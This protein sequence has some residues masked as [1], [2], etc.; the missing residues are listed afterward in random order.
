MMSWLI[1]WW[2]RPP[3][4]ER[5]LSAMTREWRPGLDIIRQ[6][7]VSIGSFYVHAL[8]MEDAGL[9][10]SKW[11]EGPIDPR[12]GGHRR[13]LYRL[14]A[15]GRGVIEVHVLNPKENPMKPAIIA[16]AL[17]ILTANAASAQSFNCDTARRSDERAICDS[18]ELSR[19]DRQLNRAYRDALRQVSNPIRIQYRQRIWLSERRGCGGNE[20][21]LRRAY[22]DRIGELQRLSY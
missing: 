19:L 12:R 10:E 22:V 11:D 16:F 1:E 13:R 17:G 2:N 9:V 7:K 4:R 21:C 3:A 20:R 5:I 14:K 8:S 6:S 15:G 18:G